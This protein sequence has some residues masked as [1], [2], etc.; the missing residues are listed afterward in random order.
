MI[1]H[2]ILIVFMTL[3]IVMP[4]FSQ[5]VIKKGRIIEDKSTKVTDNFGAKVNI[6]F[7]GGSIQDLL[8]QVRNENDVHPNV[9][10]SPE[11]MNIILPP[12][13]LKSVS[14]E[15]IMIGI[16][17][18]GSLNDYELGVTINPGI[19]SVRAYHV[20]SRKAIVKRPP[21]L[22][23]FCLK[24]LLEMGYKVEDIVT[25]LETAFAMSSEKD[26]AKL[27]YHSETALLIVNGYMNHLVAMENIMAELYKAQSVKKVVKTDLAKKVEKL[28]TAIVE[29]KDMNTL[30]MKKIE[31]LEKS[32][33]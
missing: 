1:R 23:I 13:N 6:N 19:I 18:L 22:Q 29:L 33:K 20:S 5:Q 21:S 7:K 26:A 3:F 12:I 15:Q 8:D 14:I 9:V 10:I 30:L 32:K 31:A 25:A 24:P 28:Q 27:K 11:A 17:K 16:E 2:I 4:L